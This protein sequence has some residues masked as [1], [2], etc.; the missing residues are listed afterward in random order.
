MYID[1]IKKLI[2]NHEDKGGQGVDTM[3]ENLDWDNY[4]F[5]WLHYQKL[6][7]ECQKTFICNN[8]VTGFLKRAEFAANT[9]FARHGVFGEEPDLEIMGIWL[10]KSNDKEKPE[11]M[12]KTHP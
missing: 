1:M 4:S 5:W 12:E 3:Y 10:I 8:M 7:G 6:D 11:Y 2:L 9:T